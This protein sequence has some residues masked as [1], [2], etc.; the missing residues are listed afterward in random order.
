MYPLVSYTVIEGYLCRKLMSS[1]GL[2]P[3]SNVDSFWGDGATYWTR[4]AV[5]KAVLSNGSYAKY[6]MKVCFS[7]YLSMDISLTNKSQ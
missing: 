7:K 3:G 5:I 1:I 6:Y 2:P 4:H